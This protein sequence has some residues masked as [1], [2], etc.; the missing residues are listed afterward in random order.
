MTVPDPV[1]AL[2]VHN[3]YREPGGED[4]VFATEAQ[5]LRERGHEVFTY[6]RQNAHDGAAVLRLGYQAFWNQT[7]YND[8]R[9]LIRRVR[10]DVVHLH[11]TFPLIS[12]AACYAACDEHVATVHTLHN[13]RLI[14]P[15]GLLF[16]DGRPCE[17]CLDRS[18]AWPAVRHACYRDSYAA[19]FVTAASLA[20]HRFLGTWDKQISRHIALTEFARQKFVAAGWSADRIVVK[21]NLVHPDVGPGSGDGR[22]ALYVGRLSHEK[23]IKTLLSAA[24]RI[25]DHLPLMI[26]GDGPLRA[27]VCRAVSENRRIE[28][29]G[30]RPAEEVQDLLGRATCA[31]VPS[32]WYETFCLVVAEAFAR[33]TPVVAAR[34]GALAELIEHRRTGLHFIAGDPDDLVRQVDWLLNNPDSIPHMREAARSQYEQRY[35]IE[36]NYALLCRIYGDAIADARGISG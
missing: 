30:Q 34:I 7:T 32:I 23:G 1:R 3:S 4:R 26:V 24:N 13:Y 11:N 9:S 20:T 8:V 6:A 31:I 16:R 15:N 27:E 19:S 36:S 33:G 21:P 29:L 35:S 14:C 22:F 18:V 17:D 25:T 12:P 5:V 2:L 10:P 28:W